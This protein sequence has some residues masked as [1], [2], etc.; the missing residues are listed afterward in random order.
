LFLYWL[1]A[2]AVDRRGPSQ[3]GPARP[4]LARS[5]YLTLANVVPGQPYWIPDARQPAGR[6]LNPAAFSLP[7]A[8]MQGVYPRAMPT[9]GDAQGHCPGHCP[10]GSPQARSQF[11]KKIAN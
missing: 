4:H 3:R 6:A 7:P 10:W 5:F 2:G 8:G 9:L 11:G 1:P